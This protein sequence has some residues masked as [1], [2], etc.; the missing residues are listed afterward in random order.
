MVGCSE[1]YRSI[2]LIATVIRFRAHIRLHGGRPSE[3]YE[4]IKRLAS[5]AIE[6]ARKESTGTRVKTRR[7]NEILNEE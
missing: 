2:F 1:E 4:L 3:I 5:F 6:T 7:Q